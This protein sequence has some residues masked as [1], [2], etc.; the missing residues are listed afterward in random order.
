MSCNCLDY[1]CIQL[2]PS[3]IQCGDNILTLLMADASGTWVMSYE[4]NGR[5]F[6]QNIT[7]VSGEYIELPPVFNEQYTH[8]IKFYKTD[9]SLFNDTCYTLDTAQIMGISGSPIVPSSG[10]FNYATIE[11]EAPS[12]DD[13]VFALG[14]P[15]V[16][17]DGSQSYT[18]GQFTYAAGVIT[19]TNGVIFTQGQII[20]IL[21]V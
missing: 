3:I 10:G 8:T 13:I 19:M 14:T 15:I 20:T 21:Y 7:V 6:G 17:F 11:Y 12:G 5:W 4:F 16:I 1:T 9:G 2:A 18:Q